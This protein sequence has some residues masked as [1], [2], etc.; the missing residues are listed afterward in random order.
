MGARVIG[1]G[2][3]TA[4]DDGVGLVV[5]DAL[6]VRGV[7]QGVELLA[8]AEPTQM[9]PLLETL[10]LVIVVDAIVGAETPGTVVTYPPER[11]A[12]QNLAPFSTH[13]VGAIEAIELARLLSPDE[14]STSIHIVGVTIDR[15][16]HRS[17][18]LSPSVA[19]ALPRAI[20][21]VLELLETRGL[22]V[23]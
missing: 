2:Q 15:P 9:I 5:I 19:R 6:R 1:L 14:V 4:G 3:R 17:N 12:A 22:V 23:R 18:A 7:P 16:T 8:V 13:G 21:A 10:D 20:E 11:F